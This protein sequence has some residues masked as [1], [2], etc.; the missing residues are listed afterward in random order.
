[1]CSDLDGQEIQKWAMS[2]YKWLIDD[3]IA[4]AKGWLNS[5][6]LEAMPYRVTQ[7]GQVKVKSSDKRQST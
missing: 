6:K 1:M 3:S 4:M 7:D 2:V 5:T